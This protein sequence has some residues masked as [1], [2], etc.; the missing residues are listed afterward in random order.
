MQPDCMSRIH[1]PFTGDGQVDCSLR[2]LHGGQHQPDVE[3]DGCDSGCGITLPM[4]HAPCPELESQLFSSQAWS[5]VLCGR[6][7]AF[8]VRSLACRVGLESCCSGFEAMLLM[9]LP[10]NKLN[11]MK[12]G[13]RV[14]W[15]EIP[16]MSPDSFELRISLSWRATA[17]PCVRSSWQR[18]SF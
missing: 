4:H 15:N 14:A 8:P 12:F 5:T 9:G 1:N 3:P 17:W 18:L 16:S 11:I 13:D 10:V 7:R 2:R 6:G